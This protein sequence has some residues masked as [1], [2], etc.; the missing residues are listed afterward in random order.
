MELFEQQL[1]Q[2]K[3]D[4]VSHPENLPFLLQPQHPDGRGVL[5]VHGFSATP[6]EMRSLGEHLSAE[7]FTVFGVRL[8]GH[9]TSP[10]DLA[11]RLAEDWLQAVEKGYQILASQQLSISAVGISTGALLLLKLALH[12]ELASL[13]LLSPFLNLKHFLADFA[14]PLNLLVRYHKISLAAAELP[15]YYHRRPLKG[16]I[17][18]N[19]LRRQLKTE[20][21]QVT[22]ATLVLA[23]EG[24]A[25]IAPGSAEQLFNQLGSRDKQY[26]CYGPEVP[27]VLTSK[28]NPLQQDV[29]SRVSSFLADR[30]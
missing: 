29:F 30:H 20:L 21:A 26:H 3:R 1:Q 9:G 7:G 18:I 19:R 4:G 24:D 10:E 2:A 25:T 8:P 23:S 15:F 12:K 22:A 6:R 13:I 28:K 27:H 14:W 16:I 17:Q 11:T 5:L